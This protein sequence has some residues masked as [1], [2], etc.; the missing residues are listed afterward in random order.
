MSTYNSLIYNKIRQVGGVKL[1]RKLFIFNEFKRPILPFRINLLYFKRRKRPNNVGDHLSKV[2]FDFM[3]KNQRISRW[4]LHTIRFAFIGSVIQFI[5]AESHVFGSG[6]LSKKSIEIFKKKKP[7][8]TIH[9]VRGPLTA[10]A[11]HEMGYIVPKIY[12][13]PAILLPLIYEVKSVKLHTLTIIPH[14]SKLVLYQTQYGENVLSPLTEDW[15]A[16]VDRICASNLVISASLHGII[17]AETYGVPAVFLND[18]ESDDLFKYKDYYASTG[19]WYIPMA[20][21]VEEA[22]IIGD[23]TKAPN[24]DVIRN[25]LFNTRLL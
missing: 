13:D 4:Q 6:F 25:K 19:R 15:K 9:A 20:N 7:K 16:F 24:L 12:G 8:L 2:V 5:G 1:A 11:L 18:A 22:I 3:L 14:M 21:T 10:N 23:G 17:I